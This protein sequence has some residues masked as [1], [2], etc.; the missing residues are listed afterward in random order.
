MAAIIKSRT[1]TIRKI[2]IQN[3]FLIS[4]WLDLLVLV[5]VR[6]WGFHSI[7]QDIPQEKKMWTIFVNLEQ[8]KKLIHVNI[9]YYYIF[10][11]DFQVE[12]LWVINF[13]WISSHS[14]AAYTHLHAICHKI[15][16]VC[17]KFVL[18]LVSIS[19]KRAHT[20]SILSWESFSL[21]VD[22][23]RNLI[24]IIRN[25]NIR[26]SQCC[27]AIAETL[28]SFSSSEE[29]FFLTKKCFSSLVLP[30]FFVSIYIFHYYKNSVC[31]SCWRFHF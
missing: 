24:S 12:K 10:T 13:D 9:K 31:I 28:P 8:G 2:Q 15:V 26:C 3:L 27:S 23:V 6:S 21:R 4:N 14:P 5:V 22:S 29:F 1:Q 17:L 25:T 20:H 16:A 30:H 18:L 7:I 19:H 11:W